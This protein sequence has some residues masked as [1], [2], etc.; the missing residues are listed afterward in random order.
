MLS[1]N[2]LEKLKEC[3]TQKKLS[4]KQS[5]FFTENKVKFELINDNKDSIIVIEVNLDKCLFKKLR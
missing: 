3:F 1:E 4:P 5:S 2:Q